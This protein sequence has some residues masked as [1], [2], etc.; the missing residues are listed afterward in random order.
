M[1]SLKMRAMKRVG[2]LQ[3]FGEFVDWEALQVYLEEV[4][5]I[6]HM[7]G[8]IGTVDRVVTCLAGH[9]RLTEIVRNH[10][11]IY[12][13]H[14]DRP[15]VITGYTRSST[16]FLLQIL[17]DAYSDEV[18]YPRFWETFGGGVEPDPA[19]SG[20]MRREAESVMKCM[21]FFPSLFTMHE[22]NDI[23]QAEEEIGWVGM[24]YR[25]FLFVFDSQSPEL[26]FLVYESSSASI[27]Y[28]FLK[29]MMQFKQWQEGHARR[30]ILKSPEHLHGLPQLFETF[31]DAKLVTVDRDVIPVYKSLLLLVH[32]TRSIVSTNPNPEMS[33]LA[34]TKNICAERQ[35]LASVPGLGVDALSLHFDNVTKDA[36][37]AVAR[38]AAFADLPLDEARQKR[39]VS[40]IESARQHKK[41]MGGKI[42]YKIEEFGLS[43]AD[44]QVQL[45]QCDRLRDYE[46]WRKSSGVEL[47]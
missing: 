22:V 36:Y 38:V 41:K 7:V 32:T 8:R 25:S 30:W 35:A 21:R 14:I 45:S 2:G 34:A 15:L 47:A 13:Q 43:D 17:A 19:K 20:V 33:K 39:I 28:K 44:I 6:G 3:D 11:E 40:A 37:G 31:P 26:N 42:G 10:P 12:E 46:T 1:E 4:D 29:F 27:R 9:L 16:T 23:E 18:R 5:E 24:T